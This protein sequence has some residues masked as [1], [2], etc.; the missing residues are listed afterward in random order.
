MHP[1]SAVLLRDAQD[2]ATTPFDYIVVGSG[3]GGGPLAARL[4]EGGKRVLLLEAGF[5]PASPDAATFEPGV[6]DAAAPQPA[7]E[8]VVYRVPALH[9]AATE[10]PRMTWA[11]SVRHYADDARQR[12]DQKY[13]PAQDPAAQGGTGKGGIQYPRS[14]ALG[15]CT[16]HN[17]M[18]IVKPNDSD[19]NRI[20]ALTGDASWRA[21]T[22][23][24][25]FTRIE[26][27]LY[28]EQYNGFLKRLV[29][30]YRL[31][32]K[33]LGFI[34]PRW[35]LDRGGH[36][37]NGWQLTSFI[38]PLLV[39]RIARGDR[40]FLRLLL[41]AILFLS[42][43][44]GRLRAL[45]RAALRLQLVQLLDPNFADSR[46]GASG[47]VAFIPVGTD[48]RQRT[49]LRERLLQV[50]ARWPERLV[51]TSGT[52]VTRVLF[53]AGEDAP[54]AH[55]VAAVPGSRLYQV[56]APDA[57]V[58]AHGPE[59]HFFARE[60]VV[61]AGGAFNTPQLLMLSGIGD[62]AHLH[63]HGIEGLRDA[64][65]QRVAPVVD[66]PGVGSNLQDRYEVSVVSR[67]R[68]PFTTLDGVTFDPAD[69]NDPALRQ[70]QGEGTGLYTTN[71]GAVSFLYNT[72]HGALHDPDLFVFGV[73]A[74][75]RGYYWGWS[76]QLL[77]ATMD[78][79]QDSRDL[80]TWVLLKAYTANN[81]G[82]VRLRSASAFHQPE[83][84]FR[85]FVEGPPEHV[86]DLDAL[87]SGV[88][89]VRR[90]NAA[91]PAIASEIQPG[92]S[93]SDDSEALRQWI[94]N[95]AWGH[96]ASGT[97]RMG[98]DPWKA[99]V[100]QL[101]DRDAVLDSRLRVHGVH[102]LR[103]VDASV[104]N[105]LPGYFIVTP[106][107]MVSEKAADMLLADST[108]YPEALQAAEA[109]AIRQRR[110][111]ALGDPATATVA[112]AARTQMP[113]RTVGLALSGGGIRS[114]TYSLGVLQS[115][116]RKDRLRQVDL[117]STVSGGGYT[118]SFLGRL[119]TRVISAVANPTER[120][121][122]VLANTGSNEIWWLRRHASYL[123]S[124]GRSDWQTSLGVLWRNLVSVHGVLGLLW[125]AL[126]CG[127]RWLGGPGTVEPA[128]TSWTAA[129]TASP[130][131]WLP[132]A[133][134]GCGVVP[135]LLGYWLAPGRAD[136]PVMP[137]S[138]LLAWLV[139]LGSAVFALQWPAAQLPALGAI[140]VLLLGWLA[141]ELVR[142][143]KPAG[144]PPEQVGVLVRNRLGR[145]LGLTLMLLAAT[146]AWAVLDSLARVAAGTLM[147]P[148]VGGM[149]LINVLLPAAHVLWQRLRALKSKLGARVP[150][151]TGQVVLAGCIAVVLAAF[152]LFALDVLVH[153]AFGRGFGLYLGATALLLSL[154]F[155]RATR[156]VNISA[157]HS[158]Y[159]SRLTRAFLGATNP[160]RVNGGGAEVPPGVREFH[161]GDDVEFADY[162]PE[163]RG[164]P[165][166]L[167]NMCINETADA[168]TGRHLPEDK[169]LA[170]CVGPAGISVGVRYHALWEQQG[171]VRAVSIGANPEAFHVLGRDDQRLACPE[172]LRLSQW[173]A[174]S[175]A[176]FATGAGR[177]TR[178][179]M[180]LLFGLLN[181]RL[182]YWWDSGISGDHRPGRFPPT[183]FH[184]IA[185]LP[186][187]LFRAQRMLLN[188]WRAYFQGPSVRHWYLS[189]GTHFENSGLYELV[190][191]RVELMIA[192]D[193]SEDPG[194]RFDEMALL[195]R[196]VRLDFG[197]TIEWIDP[198]R[199]GG[200]TGWSA[201]SAAP[202]IP[203]WI[204]AWLDPAALGPLS[205]IRRD[206]AAGAALARVRYPGVQ[207][208]S[209]LVL[210]KPSLGPA[211]GSLDLRCY[212]ENSPG[213]PNQTGFDQFFDD[214]Q[215]ESYRM[216]GQAGGDALF[217]P[218]S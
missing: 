4:A 106:V 27:C 192:V 91:T 81:K 191:R 156:F 141:Q 129:L 37:R 72:G 171:A 20:A 54:R 145:A 162:H 114:A 122:Q 42:R 116:A 189:D 17:A 10:D 167:I 87:C 65:N 161:P 218:Q 69:R 41:G 47:Q 98:S 109:A 93:R 110:H 133:V 102:G 195:S 132:G 190:R 101:K 113:E 105:A 88:Q 149:L 21:E 61:L 13:V 60:E 50:A 204:R 217:R 99:D 121:Q 154:V 197:A 16:A 26:K 77:R 181:V 111:V 52:L 74:A 134:A 66:L 138:S 56:G 209:W 3:A 200:A 6:V 146:L 53:R 31:A 2:P 78:A 185:G 172:P 135:M 15:G 180:S 51:I 90:L 34:H 89:F 124:A 79:P 7:E 5:D 210:L 147:L 216:L 119:F 38:S 213:F 198:A 169:G 148:V 203:A 187:Q 71:G 193:G 82:S 46:L 32:V 67:T 68:E 24:G 168:V 40:G 127:L 142:R 97:C 126:F 70:W 199:E 140:G 14:S 44:P 118:G 84:N 103:V 143:P 165:L 128:A 196:R 63:E 58:P 170:M 39:G 158:F 194:Y 175:G 137:W 83:I 160:A 43:Q 33:V 55:G 178:L 117:L 57:P 108:A 155:G 212:A 12:A 177:Q 36:G 136:H 18:I 164:G 59:L 85:S 120:V 157:L 112:A 107:F 153:A 115:L 45:L 159:A 205:A 208:V 131:W 184:R 64:A 125:V 104:F 166:H 152:L 206:A 144:T 100:T 150:A 30:L 35:Q 29:I 183:F 75:F 28:Y 179:G 186:G 48:G 95:E 215:W 62:R 49:G 96:H 182:G 80:W 188:E 173:M 163:T 202:D 1:S 8:R 201:F 211:H 19:W 174:I 25:Y 9:G 23:Q 22:M 94:S 123:T 151:A 86:R 214:Q 76:K 130:W 92:D 139:L 11:F 176:A 73:P 207:K